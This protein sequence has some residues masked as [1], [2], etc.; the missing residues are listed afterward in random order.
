[1]TKRN[2]PHN[3]LAPI[4]IAFVLITI[5]SLSASN[6][7]SFATLQTTGTTNIASQNAANQQMSATQDEE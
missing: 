6:T 1:M 2:R 7:L 5:S 4:A 3:A